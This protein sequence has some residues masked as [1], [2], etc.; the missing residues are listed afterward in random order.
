MISYQGLRKCLRQVS[1]LKVLM[2]G[3]REH[4]VSMSFLTPTEAGLGRGKV[5]YNWPCILFLP[6]QSDVNS[7]LSA[8]LEI[9]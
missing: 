5:S 9:Q 1:T 4:L 8:L 2:M 3:P 7:N 6:L